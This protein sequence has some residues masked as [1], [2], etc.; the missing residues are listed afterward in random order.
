MNINS[1]WNVPP[2]RETKIRSGDLVNIQQLSTS[3]APDADPGAGVQTDSS[4]EFPS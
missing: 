3:Y 2:T 1:L 4:V